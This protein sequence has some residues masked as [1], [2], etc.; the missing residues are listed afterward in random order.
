VAKLN[1][2]IDTLDRLSRADAAAQARDVTGSIT[3]PAAAASPATAAVPRPG[4]GLDG[5]VVRDVRRGTALIEGRMGVIEVDQGDI[6]P[7]L[8]RVDAIRKQPDGRWV[9][10]TT[11]GLITSAR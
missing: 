3:P 2:A 10:V 6:V 11:R 5:W 4:G 7:G 9:V 8:G 1:K